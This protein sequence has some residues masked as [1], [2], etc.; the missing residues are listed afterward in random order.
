[1]LSEHHCVSSQLTVAHHYDQQ[2]GTPRYPRKAKIMAREMLTALAVQKLKAPKSNTRRELRDP[3]VRGFGVR[4]TPEAAKSWIFVF[5]SPTRRKRVRITIGNVDF[6]NPDGKIAFNLEQARAKAVELSCAVREGRDPAEERNITKAA[7]VAAAQQAQA[8]TFAAVAS[9]Y[10]KRDLP[11]KRRGWEVR[12]IIE[13]ELLPAWGDKAINAISAVHVQ[14]RIEA[15]LNADKPAAARRLFG[16]ISRVFNWVIARPSYG[17]ERS[18]SDRMRASELFGR[19]TLRTR[20][21]T[22][23]ELAALW[24]AAERAGYPIGPLIQMLMLT[25][26]RR[27]EVAEASWAEIDFAAHRWTIPA[28][29][30]K[31]GAVHVVPLT[32][33]MMVT[34]KELPQF[35][36]GEFLLTSGDG[37]AAI[38]GF[39]Y[40]KIRIDKLMLAE[41]RKVAEERGKDPNK[42]MLVPWTLHDIRRTVRTHL[43]ALTVP[44]LVSELILSHAKPH[45][46]QVCDQHAYFDEK[47][48][49]LTAWG[50][51]LDRIV[52][53]PP[54]DN[55]IDL[56][57]SRSVAVHAM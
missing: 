6:K 48:V 43:S 16:I 27:S 55:V 21:L 13:R 36:G 12:Q 26:L 22:N 33:K 2:F 50:A 15:L 54:A 23:D 11:T 53:P 3:A 49:A 51:R 30:M 17:L 41:L 38:T 9:I 46:H 44:E 29:R 25:A 42:V 8:R 14:D 52:N 7:V 39:A 56:R 34:L 4:V 57:T 24:R 31:G 40:L 10:M 18:P 35:S 5:M 20:T 28:T 32:A 19:K 37:T 1:L 45:L 47:L